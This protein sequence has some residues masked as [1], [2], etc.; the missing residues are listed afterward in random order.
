MTP[1]AP[2]IAAIGVTYDLAHDP[3]H[4]HVMLAHGEGGRVVNR[5]VA[6]DR[7]D[8]D[9]L[10]K[11]EAV[12]LVCQES[13]CAQRYLAHD[14]LSALHQATYAADAVGRT[15]YHQRLLA[16]L[17]R[18]QEEDLT[19]GIAMTDAKGD[20]SLRPGRQANPD[21][22]V[23]I[24]E[25]RPDGIVLRGTKAIVTAAPY[26]HEFLVM[27]CRTMTPEDAD[28]AVACAVPVDAP[29]ITIVAR[30]AGRRW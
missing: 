16:Y 13:G 28:F 26:V 14:G 20:R 17:E 2:G 29:G 9:L 11:L 3:R 4:Q 24:A 19:L 12:R 30:P 21:V 7:T 6:V 15:E 1:I 10:H 5:M 23:H 27:P 18:V 8:D 25:R 22:Y